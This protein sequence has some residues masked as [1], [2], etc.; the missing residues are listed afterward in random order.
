MKFLLIPENNSLSHVAK[1]LAMKQKLADK[2]HKTA[3]AVSRTRSQ[4][5]KKLKIDK[6]I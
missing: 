6:H 4:F 5:L 1:C 2:G 3:V